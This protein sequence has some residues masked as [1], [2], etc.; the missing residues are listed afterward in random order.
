MRSTARPIANCA[1]PPQRNTA[2]ASAPTMLS[3]MSATARCCT[4]FGSMMVSALNTSPTQKAS[5]R[6]M[7]MTTTVSGFEDALSRAS[8]IP[9]G[10]QPV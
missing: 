1:M 6:N 2:V 4:S 7:T 3:G 8:V 5:I 9:R 10:L